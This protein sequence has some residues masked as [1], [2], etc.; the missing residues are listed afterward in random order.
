MYMEREKDIQRHSFE[1]VLLGK[2]REGE[3]DTE[4]KENRL[5]IEGTH[6]KFI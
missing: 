1:L 3:G 2:G 4:R 6:N 5:I